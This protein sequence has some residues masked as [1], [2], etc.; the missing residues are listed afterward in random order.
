MNTDILLL[1]NQLYQKSE[2][3]ENETD[4]EK[5]EV[6]LLIKT[7]ENALISGICDDKVTYKG[8]GLSAI[9]LG[10]NK[11]VGVVRIDVLKLN[12]INPLITEKSE[13]FKFKNEGCLSIPGQRVD[14]VRYNKLSILNNGK[15]EV[16]NGLVAVAIQHEIDHMNGVVIFNRKWK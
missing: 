6:E 2:I 5:K 1:C 16:Y 9:Q 12:L 14:T 10:I 4:S 15:E 8:C 3:V 13:R 7:L 11:R